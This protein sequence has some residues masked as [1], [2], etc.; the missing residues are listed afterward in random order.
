MYLLL[1]SKS[2]H[3][4]RLHFLLLVLG[5]LFPFFLVFSSFG[6]SV[7]LGA[8]IYLRTYTADGRLVS[9]QKPV[10]SC[11]TLTRICWIRPEFLLDL[12]LIPVAVILSFNLI[13]LLT[14]VFIAYQ[15]ATY[16]LGNG[17]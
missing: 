17:H 10:A 7:Y 11:A 12:E 14:A 15:S 16:R 6:V 13:V 3:C 9:D 1:A 4:D 8:D 5:F 2:V